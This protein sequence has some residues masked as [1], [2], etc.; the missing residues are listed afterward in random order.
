MSDVI[1]MCLANL[2]EHLEAE[3]VQPG[4]GAPYDCHEEWAAEH[5]AWAS[6][7]DAWRL[8]LGNQLIA[9]E[10]DNHKKEEARH[11]DS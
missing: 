8:I 10:L 1:G 7:C 6:H 11:V 4:S 2:V 3:P 5:R 9:R